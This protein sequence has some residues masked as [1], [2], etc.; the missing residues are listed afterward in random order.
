MESKNKFKITLPNVFYTALL[1]AVVII[2]VGGVS[3]FPYVLRF[4]L[5]IATAVLSAGY[6]IFKQQ[7]IYLNMPAV[8]ILITV[9]YLL[10]SVT[11]SI[12]SGKT[13]ELATVYLCCSVIMLADFKMDFYKKAITAIKVVCIVFAFSIIISSFI[14]DCMLKYFSFIVNPTNNPNVARLLREEVRW[15]HSYSGFAREKGEAAFIM[16]VGIAVYYAKYFTE[17]KFTIKD[18]AFLLILF[19]AL[20]LT[21]KRMLF[22]CPIMTA[23]ALL[24]LSNKKGRFTK[25]IPI[26]FIIICCTITLASILPQ[27]SHLFERFID[28]ESMT[29]LTGRVDLWPYSFEM[30]AKSPMIG[31]GIGSFNKY[32]DLYGEGRNEIITLKNSFHGRTVTTLSATGQDVFHNYFFPFTEGFSYVEAGDMNALKNTANK[33]TCAVMLELIQGEGGVNILD[34]SYVQSLVKFCNE[35]D[36]L[37]IVD[38]VQTGVGRTGK[39]FA[40]ENYEILPDLVTVAKGIGG[41]LPIGLCMCGEKLKDVMSPST[42]GTTFGAN[43]VVCAGANYV[44]DTITADG[45]L[46]EV[47]KKGAYIEEKVSKF[48]NVKNVRRM[49]LMIGIEFE[50]GN[51]HDIAVKCVENGLLIIT[52]KDLLRMLPPLVITYDEIDE[53]LKILE[54]TLKENY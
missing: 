2:C 41:G 52:A 53:A 42:H 38:E 9:A 24:L 33:N 40:F 43:P 30:F 31:L 35:N 48:K 17:K 34:T 27:F 4:P 20:I 7:K 36:I 13:L 12:D 26:A 19:W 22:L 5:I 15:S 21:S 6:I 16:N 46:D 1:T 50:N 45:F 51:A 3:L 28:K 8:L 44:L 32:L 37:V 11:Y 49:G 10:I 25:I 29:S 23:A 18:L 14:D 54:T 47:N 39:L